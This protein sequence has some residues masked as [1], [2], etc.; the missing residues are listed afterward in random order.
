MKRSLLFVTLLKRL[1]VV[2][3]HQP[4]AVSQQSRAADQSRTR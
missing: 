1:L 4:E 2:V 3:G